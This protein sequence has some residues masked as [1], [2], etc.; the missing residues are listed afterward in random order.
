[1]GMPLPRRAVFVLQEGTLLLVRT[2]I[3]GLST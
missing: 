3:R 2:C 1:M